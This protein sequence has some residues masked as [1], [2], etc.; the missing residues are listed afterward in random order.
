MHLNE[1]DIFGNTV[2]YHAIDQWGDILVM[3]DGQYRILAFSSLY[4]QSK[5][6]TNCPYVPVYEYIRIMMLVLAFIKPRHAIILGLGGGSI[7]HCLQFLI[8]ECELLIIELRQ[9]LLEIATDFFQLPSNDNIKTII[10]DAEIALYDCK[11]NS[12]Q[13]IFADLYESDCMSPLQIQNEFISQCVRVLSDDGWLVINYHQ[14][15]VSTSPFIKNLQS[16][17][18]ELF[19]CLATSNNTILFASKKKKSSLL[20]YHESVTQ[21]ENKLGV[22]L[23][24][25][26]KR[27]KPFKIASDIS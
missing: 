15:P 19:V 5:I 12:T 3:R 27:L 11:D 21:L 1:K 18:A 25:M 10:A 20:S 4:E 8:P 23:S 24:N 13:V 22:N 6:D 14:L 26:F 2:I 16:H 17:F 7:I 9:K